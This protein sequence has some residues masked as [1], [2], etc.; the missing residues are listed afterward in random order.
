MEAILILGPTGSGKT[1]LGETL[2]EHGVAGRKCVHFDFGEHL[3][4]VVVRNEPDEIVS[5]DDI[6]FLRGVLDSGA[7]LEDRDFPIAERILRRF[8]ARTDPEALIVLNGLP[9][10]AGQAQ[11]VSRLLPIRTV[12]HL[13]CTPSIVRERIARN[14]GG[15]RT[16]RVD[17]D[18]ASIR[19][20][21]E[22]FAHRTAPLVACL[23]EQG[24]DVVTLDVGADMTAEQMWRRVDACLSRTRQRVR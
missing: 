3:R 23:Q 21:L 9:R 24:A 7:L 8:L 2:Q 17:D 13:Q 22:V 16:G 5:V 12:I 19:A 14:T 1:P 18:L 15:D 6:A 10:H 20:K 11:S 4:Q